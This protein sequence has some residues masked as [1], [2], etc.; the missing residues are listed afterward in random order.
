M[1]EARGGVVLGGGPTRSSWGDGELLLTDIGVMACDVGSG[2]VVLNGWATFTADRVRATP[3]RSIVTVVVDGYGPIELEIGTDLAHNLIAVA[4]QQSVVGDTSEPTGE[5]DVVSPALLEAGASRGDHVDRGPV[6]AVVTLEADRGAV[7]GEVAHPPVVLGATPTDAVD[8]LPGW[9]PPSEPS[10]RATS[11]LRPIE[12]EPSWWRS[13]YVVGPAVAAGLL[14]VGATAALLGP[15]PVTTTTP[16]PTVG[17]DRQSGSTVPPADP[18]ADVGA[19]STP[20]ESTVLQGASS[21]TPPRLTEPSFSGP[22]PA[23]PEDAG[24]AT[25]D[26]S[27]PAT[28]ATPGPTSVPPPPQPAVTLASTTTSVPSTAPSSTTS[29]IRTTTTERATTT[30]ERTT[31]TAATTT[32]TTA[33]TTTERATTTTERTTTTAATTTTTVATTTPTSPG[34]PDDE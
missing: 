26:R 17:D 31:T 15:A 20:A 30:T 24:A 2:E 12:H 6:P 34:E 28:G 11:R 22:I 33:P 7:D 4:E 10:A 25:I 9:V 3:D 27:P 18:S 23:S 1:A 21:A 16:V 13:R 19:A 29:T 8:A 14:L 5:L 32:S